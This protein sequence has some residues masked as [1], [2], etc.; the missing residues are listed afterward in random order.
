MKIAIDRIKVMERIRKEI[1]RIDELAED[2]RQNG[3][4]NAI[5]VM[6]LDGGEFQLLAGFRR[7]RAAQSLGWMEIEGHV[8]SP[9]DAEAALRV[10]ISENEQREPFTF[11]EK[12]YFGLLLEEIEAVKAK[13]RMSN[14]GKGG[15][16]EGTVARPYLVPGARLVP[17]QP[18]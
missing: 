2:I 4:I 16:K 8:V 10:E 5:T 7:M 13:K 9:A 1:T 12:V 18:A 15:L 3:L 6:P 11:T 14:G 17:G